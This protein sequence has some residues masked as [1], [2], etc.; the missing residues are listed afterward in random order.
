MSND[1]I[2]RAG[3]D[4]PTRQQQTAQQRTA[5]ALIAT[6]ALAVSTM[7]AAT[8]VSIGMARAGALGTVADADGG[9]FAVAFLLAIL[10]AGMG[11]LTAAVTRRKPPSG[12]GPR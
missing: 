3:F 4:H 1:N 11:G 9:P 8:V 2:D 6:V 12:S 5:M 10:L 7:V